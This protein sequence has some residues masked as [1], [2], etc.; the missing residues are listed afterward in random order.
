MFRTPSEHLQVS[1]TLLC[2]LADRAGGTVA[3]GGLRAGG[4]HGNRVP[5]AAS[6]PPSGAVKRGPE[7][8]NLGENSAL[9]LAC[10]YCAPTVSYWRRSR[11]WESRINKTRVRLE[12]CA[13]MGALSIVLAPNFWLTHC[14][15]HLL[16]HSH[17]LA[18][19]GAGRTSRRQGATSGSRSRG[20]P[21]PWPA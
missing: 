4:A 9:P 16:W 21:C 7:R 8:R 15:A 19:A 14:I 5:R 3:E 2:A 10:I 20:W 11:R 13:N 17:V 12:A 1:T 18:A 6:D